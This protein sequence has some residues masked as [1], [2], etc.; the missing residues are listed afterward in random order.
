MFKG[1][2]TAIVTPFTDEGEVD[3]A[4]FKKLVEW[5]VQEGIDGIVCCGTTGE[6]PTLTTEEQ[7]QV[8]QT[9]IDVV[10]KRVQVIAGTGTYD[11]RKTVEMTKKAKL[12]GADGCL[13]VV[14]YYNK[15]TREGCIAHYGEVSKVGLPA[16]V[17]HHPGR[18]GITLSAAT[19][20]EIG[21]FPSI[22][23]IK[24]STGNVEMVKA[25]KELSDTPILC[26]DD[27]LALAMM[28]LGAVG[29]VS[30]VGN[31][32]PRLWTE[33]TRSFFAG[34]RERAK[35]IDTLCKPLYESLV[36]ENNPQCVKYAVSLLGKCR[37]VLR[38]PLVLPRETTKL[39]IL[40]ALTKHRSQVEH[41]TAVR[42][43]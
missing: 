18:T 40:R 6:A 41:N 9:A 5:Q 26:G 32:I 4:A 3:W 43:S 23:A 13:V 2:F 35:E 7:L 17:Y 37:P 31:V 24:D 14:P 39:E 21:R 20:T 15:P 8:F 36:I 38:L 33:M 42:L 19:L 30:I 34:D 29:V 10:N 27:T 1:T 11:T 16:I 25:L 22:A 12:L 28:E